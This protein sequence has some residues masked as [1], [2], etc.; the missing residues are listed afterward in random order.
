MFGRSS[1]VTYSVD[2]SSALQMFL[3]NSEMEV[4]DYALLE[5]W[6]A[7]WD[8]YLLVEIRILFFKLGGLVKYKI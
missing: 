8:H 6:S 2:P 5:T 4:G 1:L 7:F 3:V